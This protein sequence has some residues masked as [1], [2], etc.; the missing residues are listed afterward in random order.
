MLKRQRGYGARDIVRLGRV[1][2][3]G[4][5]RFHI[6]EGAG[7]G[8]G[9]AHDHHGGVLL[10]PAFADIRAASLLAYR[11]QLILANDLRGPGV[12]RRAGRFDADPRGLA[13]NGRVWPVRLFRV[14]GCAALAFVE[15]CDHQR[16]LS[17]TGC[18]NILS[19]ASFAKI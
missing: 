9:I 10:F 1:E 19:P 8:A 15:K 11:V 5:S 18:E 16:S 3:A 4:K 13:L 14:T 12:T 2:R 6:A 17:K 7:P